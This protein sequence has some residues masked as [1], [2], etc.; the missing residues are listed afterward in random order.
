MLISLKR[1][2]TIWLAVLLISV[3]HLLFILSKWHAI[4]LHDGVP[5]GQT[6]PDT[7]LRLTLVYDWMSG[8]GWFN[9]SVPNTNAPFGGSTSPWTRPV[10]IVLAGL[11]YL[12]PESVELKLRLMRAGL[13]AP[14]IYM[15]LL[16]TGIH[17][18][19]R[20][21]MPLPSGYMM[22][23]VLVATMPVTWNY[24]GL[25]NADHHAPLAALFIW[26]MGDILAPTPTRRRM[27]WAGFLF[28]LQ[29]WISVEAAM[30]IAVE[31]IWFGLQWLRG[32][33]LKATA[34]AWLSTSVALTTITATAI[35]VPFSQWSVPVYDSIS[36]VYAYTLTITALFAWALC[37]CHS[38]EY[39]TRLLVG[40]IG[41][42][43]VIAAIAGVYP[44]LLHGPLVDVDPFI[45]TEFL[46][47]ISEAKP[48]Y[49]IPFLQLMAYCILPFTA[50]LICLAPWLQRHR[51]FFAPQQSAKLVFFLACTTILYFYRQRWSYYTLPLSIVAIAPF[52]GALFTPEH[53]R[54]AR[55]WPAKIL[56]DLTPNQQMKRRLPFI[57]FVIAGPLMLMLLDA[58][59]GMLTNKK[60]EQT[61]NT[62]RREGCYTAARQLIRSG[63]LNR[64]LPKRA[65]I[66]APTDLG[67]EILYFSPHRIVA[68]NYH[69]EGKAIQYVWDAEKLTT[70]NALRNYL[71]TR[72]ISVI[73]TCTVVDGPKEGILEAY[74][75]GKPLPGWMHKLTY[76]LPRT[77]SSISDMMLSSPPTKPLLIKIE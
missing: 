29:L 65:T 5:I 45:N 53:A 8:G 10:D 39:R 55:H 70:A 11:A 73:L 27:L 59:S 22:A 6:D 25:G 24:F 7:W 21:I 32:D 19:I 51:A 20:T 56:V 28:G 43:L 1:I 67:T 4:P 34:L 15:V 66:L 41:G 13:L 68:S 76:R 12:Q 54:V 46:P 49:N 33:T 18:A 62:Q 31:F 48:F 64:I 9:H 57:L 50:L 40:I 37:Q 69:R 72:R 38:P 47:R 71:R 74:R 23:S 75:S 16:V 58:A 36:I 52:M 35:E 26:A 14:W 63:E 30:L 17:R 44:S 2:P 60:D 77:Q 3:P 61:I 42:G